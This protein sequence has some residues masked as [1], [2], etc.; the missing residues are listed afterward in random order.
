MHARQEDFAETYG[1]L[2]DEEIA[3]LYAEIDSLTDGAR[4]ALAAELQRRG[5]DDAQLRKLHALE[6]RHESQFDRLEKFRRKKLA[7]RRLGLNDPKGWIFAIL[8]ALV[9]SLIAKLISRHH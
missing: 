8:G 6:L 1:S 2:P 3:A 7:L 9:L 4:A 5:M